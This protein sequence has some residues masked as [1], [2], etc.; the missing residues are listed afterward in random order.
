MIG[1]PALLEVRLAQLPEC[2]DSCGNCADDQF[3]VV[4]LLVAAGDSVLRYQP[5]LSW[6]A[7]KVAF[8]LPAPQAGTVVQVLVE[9]GDSF[10]ADEIL[11]LMRL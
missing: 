9:V 1:Q 5:L 8:E 4:E 10:E 11:V 3:E 6:E 7:G 2:W